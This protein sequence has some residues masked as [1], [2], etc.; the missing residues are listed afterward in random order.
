MLSPRADN[1]PRGSFAAQRAAC[2]MASAFTEVVSSRCKSPV[3]DTMKAG[4]IAEARS[5]PCGSTTR[6]SRQGP[7]SVSKKPA[8]HRPSPR[9]RLR[10]VN[11]LLVEGQADDY[12]IGNPRF[13][14][15][16]GDLRDPLLVHLFPE[17]YDLT[18]RVLSDVEG[19]LFGK[20]LPLLGGYGIGF[21]HQP[22]PL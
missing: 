21:L 18:L 15:R 8:R 16:P 5:C 17:E 4:W 6:P 10:Y 19:N 9:R 20:G 11:L 14:A 2:R 13:E 7:R 1:G 22:L 3:A 12:F